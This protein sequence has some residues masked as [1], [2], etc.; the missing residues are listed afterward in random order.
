MYQLAVH[1]LVE[2]E[3]Q[4]R[5]AHRRRDHRRENLVRGEARRL[6]RDDLAMLVHRRERDEGAE[7]DRKGQECGDDLRQA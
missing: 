6:H 7:E 4:Q 5:D 3:A 2:G 1:A